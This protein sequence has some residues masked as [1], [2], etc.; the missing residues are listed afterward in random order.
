MTP[1]KRAK[2]LIISVDKNFNSQKAPELKIMLYNF[3]KSLPGT[4][5]FSSRF[6]LECFNIILLMVEAEEPDYCQ[7]MKLET[8]PYDLWFHH[9]NP[10]GNRFLARGDPRLHVDEELA[11]SELVR[12]GLWELVDEY[13]ADRI[14]NAGQM[15]AVLCE[16]TKETAALMVCKLANGQ[17]VS[18]MIVSK[19]EIPHYIR[20]FQN[21]YNPGNASEPSFVKASRELHEAEKEFVDKL[22]EKKKAKEEELEAC[23]GSMEKAAIISDIESLTR[24]ITRANENYSNALQST[25]ARLREDWEAREELVKNKFKIPLIKKESWA[26]KRLMIFLGQI[27]Y[28]NAPEKEAAAKMLTNKV[29][30]AAAHEGEDDKS[31]DLTGPENLMP[32]RYVKQCQAL[33]DIPVTLKWFVCLARDMKISP[34]NRF[35]L[36]LEDL[37]NYNKAWEI[38]EN[39]DTLQGLKV[40]FLPAETTV[41][42]GFSSAYLHPLKMGVFLSIK[43]I[44]DKMKMD[45]EQN[46]GVPLEDSLLPLQS[47]NQYCDACDKQVERLVKYRF[48]KSPVMLFHK[49]TKRSKKFSDSMRQKG[50]HQIVQQYRANPRAF[51]FDVDSSEQQGPENSDLEEPAGFLAE[52][53]TGRDITSIA[54]TFETSEDVLLWLK[55]LDLGDLL[56]GGAER[57]RDVC[58]E[59]RASGESTEKRTAP[60]ARKRSPPSAGPTRETRP[61]VA[62]K[63]ARLGITDSIRKLKEEHFVRSGTPVEISSD[64]EDTMVIDQEELAENGKGA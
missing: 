53:N 24:I 42:T 25:V 17:N 64:E 50:F 33:M 41:S 46:S 15:S 54:P 32:M 7:L 6:W 2:K 60:L 22:L 27:R 37:P 11:L 10:V 48:G 44:V 1:K 8:L 63:Q 49:D 14:G 12:Q 56:K 51:F 9:H 58:A 38:A 19:E 16:R 43:T 62:K 59:I 13:S 40:V 45:L 52:E 28:G 3:F 47:L 26:T 5:L 30:Y 21:H 57:M 55:C 35:L 18:T 39:W 29:W 31:F 20:M 23:V 34:E 61:R 36:I 4:L